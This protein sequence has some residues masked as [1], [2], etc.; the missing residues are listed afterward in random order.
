[1]AL[2]WEMVGIGA[3]RR[4]VRVAVRCRAQRSGAMWVTMGRRVVAYRWGSGEG[5]E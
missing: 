3:P 4:R 2:S 5:A 1:M